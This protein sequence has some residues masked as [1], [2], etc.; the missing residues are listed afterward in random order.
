M[1]EIKCLSH[2]VQLLRPLLISSSIEVT[3]GNSAD[4][5][6]VQQVF[7]HL[8]WLSIMMTLYIDNRKKKKRKKKRVNPKPPP[9]HIPCILFSSP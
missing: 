7:S 5:D 8:K 1:G 4:D 3:F 2:V 6:P 9:S